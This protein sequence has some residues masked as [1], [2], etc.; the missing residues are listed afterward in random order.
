MVKQTKRID[1]WTWEGGGEGEMYGKSNVETYI[2]IRKIG[3]Q[4]EFAVCLRKLK[5]G[6]C[7]N[8]EG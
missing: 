7:I 2:T 1:L 8:Q 4:Q 5:Q 3:S 6:F